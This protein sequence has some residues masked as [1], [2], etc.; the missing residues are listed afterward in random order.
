MKT[1]S[2]FRTT[3]IKIIE[4]KNSNQYCEEGHNDHVEKVITYNDHVE[5]GILNNGTHDLGLERSDY[6]GTR[7]ELEIILWDWLKWELQVSEEDIEEDLHERSRELMKELDK[8]YNRETAI[9]LDDYLHE[10]Q[11]NEDEQKRMIYLIEQ[12]NS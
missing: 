4:P 3:N 12:F 11:S 10:F 8:K 2:D 7:E 1:L 6:Q 5:I 9:S